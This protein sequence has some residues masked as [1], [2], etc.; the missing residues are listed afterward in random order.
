MWNM[1]GERHKPFTQVFVVC[2]NFLCF[3]PNICDAHFLSGTIH[4]FD[5]YFLSTYCKPGTVPET[6][7]TT[8]SNIDDGYF[9]VW[10]MS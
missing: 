7:D 5:K 6:E 3:S 8:M 1:E 10:E 4:L 9:I 2:H